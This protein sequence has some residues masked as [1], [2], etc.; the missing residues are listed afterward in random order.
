MSS[1]LPRLLL[2]FALLVGAFLSPLPHEWS[3]GWRSELLNRMHTPLMAVLCVMLGA[4]LS[5]LGKSK[6]TAWLASACLALGVAVLIELVQPWFGRTASAEDFVWGAAG[7]AGGS[8][9]NIAGMIP[10]SRFRWML[11]VLTAAVI[12]TSPVVWL[13]KVMAA[14]HEADRRF[15]EL[16]G[17][18][19]HHPAILWSVLPAKDALILERDEK[20]AASARMD[21]LERDWSEFSGL[22]ITGELLAESAVE[23]GIRIDIAD[24]TKTRV[25][26][27]TR[28]LPGMNHVQVS[29]P[30][31]ARPARVRQ[32]VL[33]LAAGA[34]PA[35]FRLHSVR[36]VMSGG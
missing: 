26:A 25:R 27:G 19:N 22:E 35:R 1:R 11:N 29:W 16:L 13:T 32:L 34:P 3:A 20:Q 6:A 7:V 12:A 15:P 24:D 36:L 17:H 8:A 18:A 33:F 21:A 31:G 28:L 5:S 2:T 4:F 30:E 23:L 14:R 9:W 10:A